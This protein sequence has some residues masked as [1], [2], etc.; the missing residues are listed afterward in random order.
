MNLR[1]LNCALLSVGILP[2][3]DLGAGADTNARRKRN[4]VVGRWM[5]NHSG[6]S[7]PFLVLPDGDIVRGD[8][9]LCAESQS[10]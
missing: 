7:L 2:R 1:I 4:D 3:R 9:I 10:S 6:P 5:G 8:R